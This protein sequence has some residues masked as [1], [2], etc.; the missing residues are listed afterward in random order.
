MWVNK[1]MFDCVGE[2][3]HRCSPQQRGCQGASIWVSWATHLYTCRRHTHQ[4]TMVARGKTTAGNRYT[5]TH[6]LH[7]PR[8]N[9]CINESDCRQQ[10]LE[11]LIVGY[12]RMPAV[13][14]SVK[15]ELIVGNMHLTTAHETLPGADSAVVSNRYDGASNKTLKAWHE[16]TVCEYCISI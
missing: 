4:H 7:T 12:T 6:W 2:A 8:Q 10:F 16:V 14:V 11:H 9:G 3:A 15:R 13:L 5:K 1:Y